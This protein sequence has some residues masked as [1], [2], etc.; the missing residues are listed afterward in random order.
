MAKKKNTGDDFW[1]SGLNFDSQSDDDNWDDDDFGLDLDGDGSKKKKK[2]KKLKPLTAG[3]VV[4]TCF[5]ALF[6]SALFGFI[7]YVMYTNYITYPAQEVIDFTTTGHYC[8]DNWESVVKSMEVPFEE[9]YI[10]KEIIYANGDTD[11]IDFYKKMLATIE[12][13]PY[14]VDARNVYGNLYIDSETDS[15]IKIDSYIGHNEVVGMEVID[16]EAIQF[17][18]YED[19]IN[20]LM[21]EHDLE[22]GDVNY[23][24]LL[25][26]VFLDFMN[27]LPE[28]EIPT[29]IIDRVPYMSYINGTFAMTEEEDIYIDRL[30]FSSWQF[31]DCLDRFS[32]QAKG[33]GMT[34]SQE[35]V[36]WDKLSDEEKDLVKRPEQF[37]YK[38]C[39]A[40]EWCGTYYLINEHVVYDDYGNPV[41]SGIR[42]EV[43]D[44]SISN[45]LGLYTDKVT[46]IYFDEYDELGNVSSYE[47]YPIRVELIEYGYSQDAINYFE[48]KDIRNRGIDITSDVQYCYMVFNVTNLSDK[49][50]TIT[51][52]MGLC[53]INGNM[54]A[55]TGTIYGLQG[56]VT[57]KPDETGIIETWQSSTNL[58]KKYVVWGNDFQRRD[59]LV[60][61]RLLA[62]DIENEDEFKGVT[63]NTTR[64]G[65]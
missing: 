26:D 51:E 8:L 17:S 22:F 38:N 1:D 32:I 52:N 24:N 29:K 44:G 59:N 33:S 42:A 45:P 63:V 11:K 49:E 50:L 62:G 4:W 54:Q 41:E 14:P 5:V 39:C 64:Y 46:S 23:E 56:S 31:Y 20:E 35:Y 28:D 40:K 65:E 3:K 43:G 7:G 47:V 30:L 27:W 19:K 58:W 18:K 10:N 48:A 34:I 2:K 53:D 13:H 15:G 25:V 55:R 57:L 6:G 12:Y 37:H 9:S 60:Y 16:Y 21:K 61:F 36:K